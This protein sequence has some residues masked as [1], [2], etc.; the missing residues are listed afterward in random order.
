MSVARTIALALELY[1]AVGLV[2]AVPFVA[3]GLERLDPA[4]RG[5]TLGFRLV[6]L[7]GC[8]AL[9]PWVLARWLRA[10]REAGP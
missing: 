7:P 9:W 4:A 8:A 1:L 5:G 6:V 3:R 10:R 2:L